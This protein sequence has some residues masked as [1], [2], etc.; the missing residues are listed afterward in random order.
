MGGIP[1]YLNK[2]ERG[3]TATQIIEQLAF[4]KKSFL[5][6]EF[7]TLFSSLFDDHESY[8]EII[9]TIASMRY[10]IGQEELFKKLNKSFKGYSGLIKLAPL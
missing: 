1:Y 7:N 3:L 10:G 5:L 6:D 8:A 4:K 2:I 9:R